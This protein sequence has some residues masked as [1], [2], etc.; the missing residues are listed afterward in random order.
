MHWLRFHR[1]VQSCPAETM[2]CSRWNVG[3]IR[4]NVRRH[5][6]WTS[7][8]ESHVVHGGD[9]A[10]MRLW[11]RRQLVDWT[12]MSPLPWSG[13]LSASESSFLSSLDRSFSAVCAETFIHEFYRR[14]KVLPG[15][16]H[17]R[18][19]RKPSEI[20]SLHS[21]A[22]RTIACCKHV[23]INMRVNEDICFPRFLGN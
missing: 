9:A 2:E 1:Y 21:L 19:N 13:S 6:V 17:G 23:H 7:E 20:Q 15:T 18:I 5:G 12:L 3:R 8:R 16:G 4:N 10:R 22:L 14:V 11:E